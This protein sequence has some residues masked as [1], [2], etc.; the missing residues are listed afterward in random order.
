[1][2][3]S[4][5]T[6]PGRPTRARPARA[7]LGLRHPRRCSSPS[8][9]WRTRGSPRR[10]C[11]STTPTKRSRSGR[12]RRQALPP[13]GHRADGRGDHRRGRRRRS[14]SRSTA[15]RSTVVHDGDSPELFRA[16]IP[17]VL[18]GH[19]APTADVRERRDP[20]EARRAVRGRERGPHRRRRG[21]PVRRPDRLRE[22]HLGTAGDRP[23][24]RRLPRSASSRLVG[25]RTRRPSSSRP[26][27]A[28]ACSCCSERWS[29]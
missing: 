29:R 4:P 8:A 24:R 25:L 7:A 2:E 15:S 14:R 11:T 13:A 1:M 26:A 3:L 19:W 22:R 20:R 23:R 9:S 16:G 6:A 17:V 18:E 5:R 10:R 28:T 21:R 12:P 27:G